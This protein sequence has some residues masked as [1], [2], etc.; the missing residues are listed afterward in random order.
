MRNSSHFPSRRAAMFGMVACLGIPSLGVAQNSIQ[1][2]PRKSKPMTPSEQL[3]HSTVQI[4]CESAPGNHSYGTGF[5]FGFFFHEDHHV[6]AIV[7]NKHVIAGASSCRLSLTMQ[8][9]EGVPDLDNFVEVTINDIQ[10]RW[11][12]HPDPA[13]DLAIMP[14]GDLLDNLSK[15]GKAPFVITLDPNLVP[16]DDQFAELT[17][18]ED[19]LVIGYPNGIS[20]PAHNIPVLRRGI[21]ATPPYIDFHN[22]K[23]F[24]IDAAIFPGSSGSPVLLYNQG[25]WAAR[26]GGTVVGNRI[27]LLGIVYGVMQNSVTGNISIVPAPTQAR[28]IV[29][30]LVPNNLGVCIKASRILEFEPIFVQLGFKPPSGYKMRAAPATP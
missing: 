16:T 24:L 27:K 15:Q 20:D 10:K 1:Q 5:F 9:S 26:D 3:L 8:K 25:T 7:T 14:C 21:T 22:R 19:I 30:S 28:A 18:L 13:V 12:N 6:P 4:R 11:I 29:N 17:P 23:E 2:G